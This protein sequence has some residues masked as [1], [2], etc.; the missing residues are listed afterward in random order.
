MATPT[1]PEWAT[2]LPE[3]WRVATEGLTLCGIIAW[4]MPEEWAWVVDAVAQEPEGKV[5]IV[6]LDVWPGDE[7]EGKGPM[8]MKLLRVGEQYA[9]SYRE[10][11]PVH[12][13]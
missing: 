1:L 10:A 12:R 2:P 7:F 3:E 6:P 5:R 8:W 11:T 4:P 9:I 13:G